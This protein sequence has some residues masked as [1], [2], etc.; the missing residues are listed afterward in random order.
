MGEPYG[1]APTQLLA[2][3]LS[4]GNLDGTI[5]A[6]AAPAS[7]LLGLTTVRKPTFRASNA[8]GARRTNWPSSS[9]RCCRWSPWPRPMAEV[10]RRGGGHRA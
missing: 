4:M 1:G 9:W 10:L 5:T 7:P 3:A 2:G 6:A 8:G